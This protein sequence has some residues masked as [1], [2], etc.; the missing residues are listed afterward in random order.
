MGRGSKSVELFARTSKF[1]NALFKMLDVPLLGPFLKRVMDA[2]GT[3]FTYIPVYEGVET[4]GGTA[5]HTSIVEHF[6]NEA[7]HHVI[8]DY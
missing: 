3:N 7:C 1:K 5:L 6:I 2:E 8:L 4:G